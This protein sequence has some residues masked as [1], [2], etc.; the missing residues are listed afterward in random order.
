[1]LTT[2]SLTCECLI[3][4]G[5]YIGLDPVGYHCSNDAVREHSGGFIICA[6]CLAMLRDAPHR[7]TFSWIS[8]GAP[9]S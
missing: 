1:M 9:N 5:R 3:D 8:D 6:G 2:I 4:Q 7:V